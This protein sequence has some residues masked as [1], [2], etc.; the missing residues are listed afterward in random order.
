C[1]VAISSTEPGTFTAHASVDLLSFGVSLHRETDG[2][3]LNSDDATKVFVD[4]TI[5]IAPSQTNEVGTEHT[6]TV[7]VTENLGDGNGYI[8]A[9]VGDVDLTLTDSNGA[10]S[11]LNAGASKCDDAVNNLAACDQGANDL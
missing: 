9:T 2:S 6:F 1:H 5:S 3:G 11:R 8:A 7:T 4:A 10:V